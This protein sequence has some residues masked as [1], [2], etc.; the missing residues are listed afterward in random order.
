MIDYEFLRLV[1]WGL[2]GVLLIGFAITDG[3]D[4]GVGALLT[5]VGKSDE[6]R[7]VMINTIGLIGMVTKCGLLL[8]AAQFLRR[9]H[10]FMQR[11]FRGFIS[12]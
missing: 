8:L 12:L 7:R 10:L 11:H 4:L 1:W 3:F 2:V 9:G 6:D 5:L